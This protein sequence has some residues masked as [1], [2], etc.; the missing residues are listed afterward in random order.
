[1]KPCVFV[2]R[3]GGKDKRLTLRMT[4]KGKYSLTTPKGT[5][6]ADTTKNVKPAGEW[7]RLLVRR[8]EGLLVI[9][10]NDQI[11]ISMGLPS[12]PEKSTIELR[13]EGEMNFG[14]LFVREIKKKAS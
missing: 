1:P 4:A 9:F 5:G 8:K 3:G 2:L 14:N 13:P 11:I 10:V 12:A 7:N 6:S